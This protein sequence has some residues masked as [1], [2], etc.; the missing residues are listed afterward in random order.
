VSVVVP[1]F[2]YGRYLRESIE[3][4]LSQDGV[5]L[6]VLI[7]D[8]ASTDDS[9][10][11]AKALAARN[12]R[13]RVLSNDTNMGMVPTVNRGISAVDGEYI[14]KMD[15]DDLLTPGALSRAAA[16][17]DR[18]PSVGFVYGFP[19]AFVDSPPPSAR[20]TVRSWTVW[21]GQ[22]W[23]RIRCRKGRN[24]IMQ[25]E[26]VIRA[27]V[28]DRAGEYRAEMG[29]AP[30][31]DM[32]LRLALIADVGR[33]NGAHQGYYRIHPESWQRSM[34]DFQLRD[35]ET[36][37]K[38]FSRLF[39]GPGASLPDLSRLSLA[40]RRAIALRAIAHVSQAVDEGQV[41][42]QPIDS[43]LAL[44]INAWPQAHSHRQWRSLQR[45]LEDPSS[46][47][48]APAA[49]MRRFARDIEGRLRWRRWR[50][51]GV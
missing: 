9:L 35:L 34:S 4:V 51:S 21:P 18:H 16:L 26:V 39:D 2:N 36:Q 37:W 24:C 33:I 45:R 22:D 6:D 11:V 38:I 48:H 27:T 3:S 31:F 8:D 5:D 13:V 47:L 32:W 29:H 7:I 30:D 20:T 14:V 17:L 50:W 25:P 43:Y 23:L 28:L 40:A 1:L 44:A 49:G 10:G 12:G 46:A 41:S 42:Q 19:V 15:A